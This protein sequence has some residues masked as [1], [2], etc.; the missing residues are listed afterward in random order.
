MMKLTW[1]LLVT[2]CL[3]ISWK[4]VDGFWVHHHHSVS[5]HNEY[6]INCRDCYVSLGGRKKK[7]LDLS[8]VSSNVVL[9]YY[10]CDLLFD[11][12]M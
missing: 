7:S 5:N 2:S 6:H 9:L 8:P 3:I 1:I 4:E 11:M 10:S 12:A